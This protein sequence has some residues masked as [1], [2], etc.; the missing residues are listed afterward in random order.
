MDALLEAMVGIGAVIYHEDTKLFSNEYSKYMGDENGG[1]VFDPMFKD[2]I[3]GWD[4]AAQRQ[5]HYIKDSVR[6]GRAVGLTEVLGDYDSIYEARSE[7]PELAK[8]WD[9][10]MSLH[11]G[12]IVSALSFI[13]ELPSVVKRIGVGSTRFNGRVLDWCGN[14]GAN[15]IDLA[16]SDPTMKLTVLDLPSQVVK[17]QKNIDLNGL[18]AQIDTMGADLFD[19]DIKFDRTY[20][21]VFMIHTIREWSDEK[22]ADFLEII[23]SIL[24]PGGFVTMDMVAPHELGEGYKPREASLFSSKYSLYFLASAAEEQYPKTSEKLEGMLKGVGF[25]EV[26]TIPDV[27]DIPWVTAVKA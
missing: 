12:D 4:V 2:Y 10:W 7:D 26:M 13:Y 8:D 18:Q 22:V 16:V 15:S 11:D 24:K 3:L 21:A 27:K 9:T 6:D 1:I 5:F 19:P 14:T 23:Y 20:D 25:S 17:A